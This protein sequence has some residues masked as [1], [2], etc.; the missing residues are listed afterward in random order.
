MNTP[1][2]KAGKDAIINDTKRR[3][4][5]VN[6][7]KANTPTNSNKPSSIYII[8][9]KPIPKSNTNMASLT[10]LSSIGLNNSL[11]IIP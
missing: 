10:V 11:R 2:K 3:I 6:K 9:V 7:E 1:N 5:N 8:S 4:K